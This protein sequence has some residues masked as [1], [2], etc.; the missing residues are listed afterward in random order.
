V[1][2]GSDTTG[3]SGTISASISLVGTAEYDSVGGGG[4]TALNNGNYVVL[5]PD[6]S[7]GSDTDA[8]AVTFGSGTTGVSGTVSSINSLVGNTEG[9]SVGEYVTAFSNG[10]YVVLTPAWANGSMQHAGAATFGSGTTGVSGTV[11][12][13][14]SEVGTSANADLEH[15]AI[16]DNVNDTFYVVFLGDNGGLVLVGSQTNGFLYFANLSSST[17]TYGTATTTIS[18]T[19]VSNSSQNVPSGEPIAITIDGNTEDATLNAS[20]QFSVAFNTSSIPASATPYTITIGYGGDANFSSVTDTSSTLTVNKAQP[21]FSGLNSHTILVGQATTAISGTLAS[22]STQL[23]PKGEPIDVTINGVEQSITLAN[24]DTFSVAFKTSTIPLSATPYT[25]T[26]SYGGDTNFSPVTDTST[27]LT[28]TTEKPVVLH[29]LQS[30]TVNTGQE[31]Q[32]TASV[33]GSPTPSLQWRVSTNR[34][35]TFTAITSSE[36]GLYSGYTTDTLAITDPTAGM[37]DYEYEVVFTNSHG[38]AST[39]ATLLVD[40]PPAIGGTK[41]KQAVKDNTTLKPFAD[42]TLTGTSN[43]GEVENVTVI[44]STTAGGT[45][46]ITAN[47][48][49]T[50]GT[51]GSYANGVFTDHGVTLAQAQKVLRSLTFTPTNHQVVP[52]ETVTTYFTLEIAT[53]NANDIQAGTT[54]ENT[55]TSAITTAVASPTVI[56]GTHSGQAVAAGNTIQPFS[57][58]TLTNPDNPASTYT[59]TVTLSNAANGTLSNLA[60]GTYVKGVYT[61]EDVTNVEAQAALN[62]LVFTPA[63]TALRGVKQ[64]TTV[65]T[66]VITDS[67][68]AINA[69]NAATSVIAN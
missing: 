39:T 59:L 5:S 20:D 23:V 41:S 67:G 53:F 7:N 58:V 38:S 18:G 32:F 6:W 63:A 65:F 57:T 54:V 13:A 66:I 26:L 48:T 68:T 12:A 33:L 1:T 28:V 21:S 25:I 3:V 34:G 51:G 4:V 37:N 22:N 36:K 61:L 60:G 2:F 24:S 30:L 64:I 27:T 11:S 8:G 15:S 35:E 29:N 49:L 62:G 40:A 69:K 55:T 10:S 43:P 31:A 9:E 44:L 17:I 45:T 50:P 14:N 52:P 56:A 47:G 19:L 16:L 46:P 42:V